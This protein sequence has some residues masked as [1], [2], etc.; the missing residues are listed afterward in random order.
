MSEKEEE[1]LEKLAAYGGSSFEPILQAF[2]QE[3]FIAL[4]QQF[5]ADHAPFFTETCTDGSHPLVWTQYHS[6]YK[7][8]FEKRLSQILEELD[9]VQEDF[10]SFCEW[11]KD[12]EAFLAVMFAEARRHA[13]DVQQID[14]LIPEGMLPGQS[15]L[16]DFLGAQYEVIIP[17]G[18]AAGMVFQTTVTCR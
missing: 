3:D 5:V 8:I 1:L 13:M 6:V 14:V 10:A 15:L 18:Y 7:E 12:Y 2:H 16:V 9:V 11:L 17:E 4:V